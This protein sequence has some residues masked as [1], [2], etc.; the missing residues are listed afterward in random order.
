MNM[1][2][3][4]IDAINDDSTFYV[5]SGKKRGM[6]MQLSEILKISRQSI[7]KTFKTA[8]IYEARNGRL[9]ENYW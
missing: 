1:E 4:P 6:T 8:N 5:S 9:C 7:E 2:S 3:F